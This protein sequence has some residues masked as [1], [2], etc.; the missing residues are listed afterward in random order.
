MA[1][2]GGGEGVRETIETLSS[3]SSSLS[4]RS[5]AD[6][7]R[8]EWKGKGQYCMFSKAPKNMAEYLHRRP[9]VLFAFSLFSLW[10]VNRNGVPT[11]KSNRLLRHCAESLNNLCLQLEVNLVVE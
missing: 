3:L 11:S 7:W 5:G 4:L 8:G 6:R 2:E 10:P 1:P 9:L